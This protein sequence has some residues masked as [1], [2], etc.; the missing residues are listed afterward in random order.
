MRKHLIAFLAGA[1]VAALTFVHAEARPHGSITYTPPPPSGPCALGNDGGLC[2]NAPTGGLRINPNFFAMARQSGQ[3]QYF[4]A[5]GVQTNNPS[6][7][8]V[9]GFTYGIGQLTPDA[10]LIDA[11]LTPPTGCTWDAG[12]VTL[13]CKIAT[14]D[15][16]GYK[17]I[18]GGILLN[19]NAGSGTVVTLF[20]ATDFHVQN[21]WESCNRFTGLTLL[22]GGSARLELNN[23]T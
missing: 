7:H 14:V 21:T 13:T 6:D 17:L 2:A 15:F 20:K 11:K 10:G 23:G 8:D 18:G 22:Q 4:N 9:G 19:G 1:S 5:A 12:S 16:S 3:A